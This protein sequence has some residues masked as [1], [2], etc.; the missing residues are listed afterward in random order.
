MADPHTGRILAL[1]NYPSFNPNAYSKLDLNR[2]RNS[3]TKLLF[4]PGSITKPLVISYALE[5]GE[6]TRS[7]IHNCEKDGRYEISK[8]LYI[9]DEHPQEFMTTA[10][11]LIHSSNICTAKVAQRL[12]PQQTFLALKKF[13]LSR[14]NPFVPG[15]AAGRL[16]EWKTWQ[17]IQLA[18]I[19]FG[20]GFLVNGLDIVQ[21]YSVF[22][23]GGYLVT[24]YLLERVESSTG[25]TVKSSESGERKPILSPSTAAAMKGFLAR[26]VREGTGSRAISALYTTGGKTGTAE[27][28]DL[29]LKKYSDNLRVA[30][31]AGFAPVL[32]PH[33]VIF[34]AI[35]E[36]KQKPYYGGRWAAPAFREIADRSLKYLNVAPDMTR[37]VAKKS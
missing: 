36:P 33:L 9:H 12:G 4:E 14:K 2:T 19:A 21:A 32:D 34:V 5:E 8:G 15:T 11:I 27:K 22:A 26:V 31:F 10:E 6:T 20:Q 17:P 1:A 23:N 29:K 28:Y 37:P 25:K 7:E 16:S 30:S 24:P 13:G 18:N 35:D 3:A